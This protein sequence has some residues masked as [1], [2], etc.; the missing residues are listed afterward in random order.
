MLGAGTPIV[1]PIL[2]FRHEKI[3]IQLDAKAN[4]IR[5]STAPTAIGFERDWDAEF[6]A[7]QELLDAKLLQ[8]G[9]EEPFKIPLLFWDMRGKFS[10]QELPE[11]EGDSTNESMER[12]SLTAMWSDQLGELLKQRCTGVFTMTTR[13][14]KE[15]EAIAISVN[16][17]I[18]SY[19]EG[20]TE[21][22]FELNGSR[23]CLEIA[24]TELHVL[25]RRLMGIDDSD[26]QDE[27][28]RDAA[29]SIASSICEFFN[30]ELV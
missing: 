7:N 30:I 11:R 5:L 20:F 26:E 6:E 28:L 3:L 8:L 15:K 2:Q 13:D 4:V 22:S 18:D 19:L 16:Q 29:R 24:G 17:G 23:L 21:S 10:S 14:Q 1:D 12:I 25:V 9:I 27:E